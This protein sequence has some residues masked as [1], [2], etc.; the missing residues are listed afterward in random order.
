MHIQLNGEPFELPD[1]ATVL[2]LLTRLDLVGRR[3]AVEL[4]LDIVP[5]SQHETTALN[6][7]DQ[8]EVVHAIGGG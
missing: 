8:V 3:V 5:R 4:N 1:G 7:G 2:A 6:E